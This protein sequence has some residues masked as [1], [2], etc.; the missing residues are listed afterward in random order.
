MGYRQNAPEAICGAILLG[1][2]CAIVVS[3]IAPLRRAAHKTL[4]VPAA[5]IPRTTT[6]EDRGTRF[7]RLRGY[8]RQMGFTRLGRTVYY[9]LSTAFISPSAEVLL[10]P[11]AREE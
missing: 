8:Y 9:A 3:G 4:G 10:R 5:W 1:G 7:S 6:K 11:K 2:G